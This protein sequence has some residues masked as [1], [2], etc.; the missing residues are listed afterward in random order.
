MSSREKVKVCDPDLVCLLFDM[1]TEEKMKKDKKRTGTSNVGNIGNTA[2]KHNEHKNNKI[3]PNRSTS[4][5]L[6]K[7]RTSLNHDDFDLPA[8]NKAKRLATALCTHAFRSF[9]SRLEF[10]ARLVISKGSG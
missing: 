4:S 8:L 9:F 6:E 5:R 2:H 10:V 3:M 7:I 1:V